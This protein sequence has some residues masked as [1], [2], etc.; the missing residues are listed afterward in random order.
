MIKIEEGMFYNNPHVL[1][2]I[3]RASC[4]S[5]DPLTSKQA[6]IIMYKLLERQAELDR[7]E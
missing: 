4:N 5:K 6:G 1:G 3:N 2:A 7:V